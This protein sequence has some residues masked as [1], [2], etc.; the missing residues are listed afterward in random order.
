MVVLGELITYDLSLVNSIWV[1]DIIDSND[2]Y[3]WDTN[4]STDRPEVVA[5][6]DDVPSPGSSGFGFS[7]GRRFWLLHVLVAGALFL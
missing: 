4:A 3:Q 2:L 6:S 7:G 5:S 1:L